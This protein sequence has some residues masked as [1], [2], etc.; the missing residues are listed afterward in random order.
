MSYIASV[1]EQTASDTG[2]LRVPLQQA[3]YL[4][5]PGRH[6]ANDALLPLLD[7]LGWKGDAAMLADLLESRPRELRLGDLLNVMQALGFYA[8]SRREN[9][10]HLR[11]A[12]LP[13]LFIPD[14][15]QESPLLLLES[16]GALLMAR[17]VRDGM[18]RETTP[19]ALKGEYWTFTPTLREAIPAGGWFRALLQR[20]RGLFRDVLLMGVC[21]NLLALAVPIFTMLVYDR[22]IGAGQLSTLYYLLA[23]VAIALVAE[24]CLRALRAHLL[25]WFGVRANHLI[26]IAMF[27][28]LLKLDPLTI[29]RASPVA[30]LVRAKTIEAVRDFL[31]GQGFILFIELPFLPV[32]LLA[33]LLLAPMLG[34]VCFGTAVLLILLLVTQQ[35]GIRMLAQR[36]AR[37]LSERQRD[38]LEIFAKLEVIRQ[39]GVSES[40]FRRFCTSN[41]R[42]MEHAS[43][44]QWQMQKVEHGVMAISML[45]GLTTLALGVH[46]VWDGTLTPGGLI[47]AMIISWRMLMPLQQMVAIGPRLEQVNG[48]VQQLEQLLAV[49]PERDSVADSAANYALRGQVEL[50]N[51]AMRYPRQLDAVFTGLSMSI[52]AGEVVAIAGAN[53]SGKSSVLKMVNGMYKQAAGAVRIDGID[54]RQLDPLGLRRSVNYIPQTAG[55]FEGTIAENIRAAAPFAQDQDMLHALEEADALAEVMALPD[56]IHTR[57]THAGGD[58]P[59]VLAFK[60][61]LARAYANPKPILLC[62]E[63]PYALLTSASGQHFRDRL[64]AMRGKQTVMLVVHTTDLLMLADQAVFLRAHRRPVVGKPSDILPLMLEQTHGNY[65]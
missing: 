31:T 9:L 47:A 13:G 14:D 21:I 4:G 25:A 10:E 23:G 46:A 59:Q 6:W 20:F 33:L 39:S 2:D 7:M 22:V 50:V 42:A 5:R 38:A 61:A 35:R 64:A 34:A 63:L 1:P 40:L 62:D 37:A 18:V 36:S 55:L 17:H 41:D 65:Q 58:L 44:L 43:T 53:G 8:Q 3:G 30:Q 28:R 16:S 15:A 26:A 49:V 19:M 32:L 48:G 54:I 11:A 57:L 52:A 60:I 24:G 45:G 12:S 56:G 29:E 51:A 27:D